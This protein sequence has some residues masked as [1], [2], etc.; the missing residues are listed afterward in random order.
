MRIE[1]KNIEVILGEFD[2]AAKVIFEPMR[3]NNASRVRALMV[4]AQ[5]EEEREEALLAYRQQIVNTCI[6]VINLYENDTQITP[7]M[8]KTGEIYQE[9]MTKI[10]SGY[11]LATT[12][13]SASEVEEKNEPPAQDSS[14]A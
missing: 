4:A 13:A 12:K 6:K 8:L 9:T 11:M 1:T 3:V 5:T 2:D 14:S 10:I 7:E